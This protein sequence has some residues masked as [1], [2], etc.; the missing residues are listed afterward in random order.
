MNPVQQALQICIQANVPAIAWG[1]PGVG[2]TSWAIAVAQALDLPIEV[3]ITSIREPQDF[4]GLPVYDSDDG[5]VLLAPPQWAK[6]LDTAGKGIVFFDEISTAPPA[7]QAAMLRV[8]QDRVVGDM[9]LP[10]DVVILAA[11][12]PPGEA[13]GGWDLAPPMANRFCHID[14]PDPSAKEWSEGMMAGWPL[15]KVTKL[16]DDWRSF[17]PSA[18]AMVTSFIN[19]KKTALFQMPKNESDAGKAW[20]SPRSWDMASRLL[21]ASL[22][23]FGKD[24]VTKNLHETIS[25]LVAGCIG[26]GLAIEFL[27]YTKELDL[28]DPEELLKDPDKLEVTDRTDKMYAILNSV[29][30]AIVENNTSDRWHAGWFILEKAATESAPDVATMSAKTLLQN[31]PDNADVP[32]QQLKPFGDILNY[33]NSNG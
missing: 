8:T 4:G 14:W 5:D 6:R 2:K 29:I 9:K 32:V 10:D 7:V 21:A 22:A 27:T 31:K 33:L 25:Q 13:A 17:M 24:A 26:Q 30:A 20:A 19:H 1:S 18:K 12:N 28:P 15:P 11:A 23:V 16:P 3:V